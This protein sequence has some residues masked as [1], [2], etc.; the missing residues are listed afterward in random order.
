MRLESFLTFQANA[1]ALR[2]YARE[3]HK[4]K[5]LTCFSTGEQ[6]GTR[7]HLHALS[8]D[9]NQ[10]CEQIQRKSSSTREGTQA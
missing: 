6:N 7:T 9:W 8:P 1:Y 2:S 4:S 10:Y 3:S 5:N